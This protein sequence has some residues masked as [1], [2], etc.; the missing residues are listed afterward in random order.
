MLSLVV[1]GIDTERFNTMG[2]GVKRTTGDILSIR[3]EKNTSQL[4]AALRW[5]WR[6]DHGQMLNAHPVV[7]EDEL[8]DTLQDH[9]EII[10][11]IPY[12]HKA[13]GMAAPALVSA[14]HYLCGR[15]KEGDVKAGIKPET[16]K[17]WSNDFFW[18]FVSGENLDGGHPI[19]VLRE[20]L[21]K[22]AQ[23]RQVTRDERKAPM[24]IQAW[25]LLRKD[26]NSRVNPQRPNALL[27]RGTQARQY[28]VIL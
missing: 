7:S 27:W 18:Q 13:K 19:L 9:Q 4:A 23:K 3:G 5:V 26:A 10:Q 2:L 24:I 17:G 20:L 22:R 16:R 21:M 25:N 8:A 11:S 28:P 6:H 14:M 12:G 15:P 1:V